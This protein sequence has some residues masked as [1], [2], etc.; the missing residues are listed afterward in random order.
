MNG[1]EWDESRS[2]ASGKGAYQLLLRT[3]LVDDE[4]CSRAK[5]RSFL[6]RETEYAVVAEC[7][8]V[9]SAKDAIHKHQPDLVVLDISLH[10]GNGLDLLTAFRE[11]HSPKF[12]VTSAY[13]QYAGTACELGAF[14]YLLKPFSRQRFAESLQCVK[15]RLAAE[16]SLLRGGSLANWGRSRGYDDRLPL[17]FRGQ[18]IFVPTD[19]ITYIHQYN[20]H[21]CLHTR[22]RALQSSRSLHDVQSRLDPAE[23]VR[24]EDAL[25]NKR[26][27]KD[28]AHDES[29][30]LAVTLYDGTLLHEFG[31]T[32]RSA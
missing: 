28:F 1:S 10:N 32:L 13:E 23:F 22:D 19:E 9:A 20:G 14:D 30:A 21:L 17:K 15:R 31:H 18:I 12:I 8:D 5:V 25:V 7:A 29:G 27:V 16:A 24:V 3:I 11:S 6:L 2:H 4:L 26:V